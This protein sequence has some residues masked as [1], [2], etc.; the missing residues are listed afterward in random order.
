MPAAQKD[1]CGEY[2]PC[3]ESWLDPSL[4]MTESPWT[5]PKRTLQSLPVGFLPSARSFSLLSFASDEAVVFALL[6]TKWD[7]DFYFTTGKPAGPLL[8]VVHGFSHKTR[9]C[10]W[11]GGV[12]TMVHLCSTLS[13]GS[14]QVKGFSTR[15]PC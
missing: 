6:E 13:H 15:I 3:L 8:G 12:L 5:P 11:K 9:F 10:L 2:R 7:C 14:G 4:R 1:W